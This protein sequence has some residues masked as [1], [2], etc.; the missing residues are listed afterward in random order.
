[1]NLLPDEEEIAHN[2]NVLLTNFRLVEEKISTGEKKCKEI[3]LKNLDSIVTQSSVNVGA[4]V[5]GVIIAI[6]SA[7]ITADEEEIGAVGLIIGVIVIIL[8]FLSST[9]YV[10]FNA[11]TLTIKQEKKGMEEFTE[12][13]RTQLYKNPLSD[14]RNQKRF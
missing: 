3:P 10:K 6:I 9:E 14:S 7:I 11:Q 2:G 13:V 8:G 4:I 1:M 12:C 5:F